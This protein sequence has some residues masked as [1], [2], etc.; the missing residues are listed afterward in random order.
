MAAVRVS[1]V[2]PDS[3]ARDAAKQAPLVRNGHSIL[4]QR[5]CDGRPTQLLCAWAKLHS[6]ETRGPGV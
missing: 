4:P 3:L 1:V 2:N 5:R 6:D